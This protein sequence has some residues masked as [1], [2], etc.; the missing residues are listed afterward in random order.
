[1][2]KSKNSWR[3]GSITVL[4]ITAAWVFIVVSPDTFNKLVTV[5]D[6]DRIFVCQFLLWWEPANQRPY[7]VTISTADAPSWETGSYHPKLDERDVDDVSLGNIASIVGDNELA[8]G[9]PPAKDE[10]AQNEDQVHED[11]EMQMDIQEEENRP[12]QEDEQ[13]QDNYMEGLS[14]QEKLTEETID[15][16]TESDDIGLLHACLL[17]GDCGLGVDMVDMGIGALRRR[18]GTENVKCIFGSAGAITS[19]A[20]DTVDWKAHRYA[21]YLASTKVSGYWCLVRILGLAFHSRE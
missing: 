6:C 16:D 1:M 19:A 18:G 8:T 15:A 3:V 13:T 5:N 4:V 7:S 10:I 11:N 2:W 17:N 9:Y 14:H 12:T 20:R 21:Y